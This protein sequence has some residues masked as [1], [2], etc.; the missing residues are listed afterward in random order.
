MKL[1]KYEL[2]AG[3]N[4]IVFEFVSEGPLGAIVKLIQFTETNYDDVYNLAFGDKD[5]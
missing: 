5:A 4:F 3:G 1:K 2:S